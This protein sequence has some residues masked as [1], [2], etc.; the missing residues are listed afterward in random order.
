MF[1]RFGGYAQLSSLDSILDKPDVTVEELLDE[2]DLIQELKQQNSKLIEYLR[3]ENVLERLL[4]YVI[5]AR[6][7]EPD[8][9]TSNEPAHEARS[10]SRTG[11][12]GKVRA[13]S[14]S[15]TKSDAGDS[16][17]S[18]EERQRMKYAYVSCEILSSEVWSISEAVL[19]NQDT[20]RQFWAYIKQPA[21]LDPVQ[22][23]YF[24]KV[25]ESLLDRKMEE[26]LEFFKSLDNV[27]TDMLQH[28]DCP[29]IMDLLLKIISLEKSEGGQGIV[30]WLQQQ[31][32]IPRLISFLAP[33]Q[34]TSTQTSAGDFLK[35][36][37]TI[38]ANATTQDQSVIGPNE[39]TRQL[40]SEQCLKQL[41]DFMLQGGNPLTVG[42]GIIIE[43]IRKNNS[44]YDLENQ[45][46]P[47]P[48]NSDPIYLGTLLRQFANHIPQFMELVNSSSQIVTQRDGSTTKKKRELKTAFGEKIEPLGFDRFKTC[49]LMAELLHC[50]NMA[51]LNERGSEAEVRRRDA[52]RER[53]KADGKLTSANAGNMGD[54]S[55]SVDS[56]G[57]HH[58]R[59]PSM[60]SPAE[61][62]PLHV[63]NSSEDDFEKVVA[64]E[65]IPEDSK[66]T[67]TEKEQI[68]EPLEPSPKVEP[69]DAPKDSSATKT[70]DDDGEFVDEPLTPPKDS[71]APAETA[72]S[73]PK[74]A[75]DAE[76]PTSAGL[77]AK[78]D[79][80]EL[81]TDT[82]MNDRQEPTEPEQTDKS[83]TEPK[84]DVK[85]PPSLLTQQLSQTSDSNVDQSASL[86]PHPDDKPAPL[87][88]GKNRESKAETASIDTSRF[89]APV[90]GSDLS[91]ITPIDETQSVRSVVFGSAEET[92][93]FEIDI[94]GTP[95][96]GDLL[97]I[98]FVENKVVPTILDFFFRF[99]W[100][101]FLHNVV[102]DVV[103]QV[104]NGQMDRGY[105][106]QLAIDLFDNGG[107]TERIIKGQQESDKSHKET[108][109]RLGY[110]GH[111]TLIAEE[112]LKFTE[113]HT[114]EV[115]SQMVLEK[116]HAQEW[117]YYVEHI[118]AETRERDNAI[119][120]GV[121]PDMSVGP[122]QAVL[123]AVN[124]ANNN[125]GGDSGGLS[126]ASLA[127]NGNI[128]L[129]SMEL[130][131]AGDT[132]GGGYTFSGGSL[133][134]GF[135]NSSDEEDEDM[136]DVDTEREREQRQG[137]VDDSEQP[138]APP[139]LQI[140]PSRARRQFALRLA[141]RKAQLESTREAEE[142]P[143][144]PSA[145]GKTQ[146]Q[147]ERE[148]HQ[149]FARM[150]EG[151]EDSSDDDS[152]HSMEG[153]G[154]DEENILGRIE[155]EGQEVGRRSPVKVASPEKV[156][157]PELERRGS[158]DDGKEDGSRVVV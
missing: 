66:D 7:K 58:A 37:I 154:D 67:A 64:P 17:E 150:F 2:S 40:V 15:T 55:T 18:K 117:V 78:V 80:L 85:T 109:M 149:R 56:Q 148:G 101:N 32:L 16:E 25:N 21:P 98:T 28:V 8:D 105:N 71:A 108:S 29:V 9:D 33:E 106:R 31:N 36:I 96:V 129:D 110:M 44:D 131:N 12:F 22:A 54:F 104:F 93:G 46:G 141:Q 91:E 82:V 74:P 124:A 5:A 132:E 72:P 136:D 102:Y 123:N 89:T 65:V 119:L 137:P 61:I 51:L 133:L 116:V 118:L 70:A 138:T 76:S 26:M 143:D 90:A 24:T 45:I 144:D 135:T 122:R 115:L 95:V 68:G 49:E 151:I 81:D 77:T 48:K 59:A 155:V 35:A 127:N 86:S 47:V 146:E 62:K 63:Q 120:G 41:I 14:T 153:V 75:D 27:V 38:S 111:L 99:P 11:F 100:N 103:Q 30:D 79:E 152:L 4:R 42:V 140:P 130:T 145:P 158:G 156:G 43:V 69:R 84:T 34:S 23:G 107:I 52:E 134:S 114:D 20:L 126:N 1:W 60:D 97:K 113:R 57:F 10:P 112:V 87:F 142:D 50:S 121:R 13:R 128:G 6:P 157:S 125:F 94:D 88:A 83:E 139:P 3:D 73:P 19:E 147:E 39:L 92:V 53:L